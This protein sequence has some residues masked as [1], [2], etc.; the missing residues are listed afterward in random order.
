MALTMGYI[1][2]LTY[3]SFLLNSFLLIFSFWGLAPEDHADQLPNDRRIKHKRR[4]M[5]RP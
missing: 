1:R 4:S 5:E 3:V 2:V